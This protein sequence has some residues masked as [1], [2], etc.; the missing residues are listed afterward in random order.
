MI[1]SLAD[2]FMPIFTNMGAS[3]NDV[4]STAD[5]LAP[6][7]YLILGLFVAV[8]V[9][10]IAAHWF[11][12]KGSRHVVRWMA[13]LCWVLITCIIV[14]Y[15]CFVPMYTTISTA[16]APA[17]ELSE[18]IKLEKNIKDCIAFGDITKES[19]A[20]YKDAMD[21]NEFQ[22]IAIDHSD[23]VIQTSA[24]IDP[25]L[26]EHVKAAAKPLADIQQEDFTAQYIN[27]YDSL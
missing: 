3:A 13:A 20:M 26:L 22:K 8:I 24:D 15:I 21:I 7:I 25:K 18:E 2:L 23:G 6:Y 17:Y 19:L 27:F 5:S 16:L 1:H 4:Y 14:N 11:A 9:I 12:K 10:M